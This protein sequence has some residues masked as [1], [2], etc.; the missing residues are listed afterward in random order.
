MTSDLKVC[1]DGIFI[2]LMY[3]W[4]LSIVL[5]LFETHKVSETGFCLRLQVE[6][7]QLG[8]IDKASPYFRTFADRD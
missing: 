6:P 4:T 1:D 3:F 8:P 5:F 2:E 7:N